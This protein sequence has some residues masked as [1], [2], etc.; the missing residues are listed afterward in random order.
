[1]MK[2]FGIF[3]R[4]TGLPESAEIIEILLGCLKELKRGNYSLKIE[5][6]ALSDVE[7]YDLIDKN[8]KSDGQYYFRGQ[9]CNRQEIEEIIRENYKKL[10]IEIDESVIT[11]IINLDKVREI[12]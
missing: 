3:E 1:M 12:E 5:E 9:Y 4:N 7:L 2:A 10:V 8:K 11:P 6:K